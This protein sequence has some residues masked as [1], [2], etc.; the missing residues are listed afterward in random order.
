M[1]W[2]A[3]ANRPAAEEFADAMNRVNIEVM[4]K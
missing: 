3:Q 4:T 1:K 2:F